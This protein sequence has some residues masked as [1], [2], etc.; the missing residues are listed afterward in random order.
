MRTSASCI[1]PL[2]VNNQTKGFLLLSIMSQ[3]KSAMERIQSGDGEE[4]KEIITGTT[5]KGG[6]ED[7]IDGMEHGS[8]RQHFLQS[9]VSAT[10]APLPH[11]I[12]SYIERNADFFLMPVLPLLWCL[13]LVA[14]LDHDSLVS[15]YPM[16]LLGV[17]SATLANAVPVGGGIVFVPILELFGVHIKLGTAFAVS[18]MT[19]GNGVF[20]FLNWMKKNPRVIAWEIMPAAILPAWIG[21]TIGTLRPL[22]PPEECRS[23]FAM[24][25]LA[26][27]VLVLRGLMVGKQNIKAGQPFSI[28]YTNDDNSLAVARASELHPWRTRFIA[29]ICSFLAGLILVAHIGIGNAVTSFLVSSFVWQLPAKQSVVTSIIIGG[30][31]SLCPFLLHLYILQDVPIALWVMGLPG[32]YFGAMIAPLVHEWM[33]IANV[34]SIFVMFLLLM[35]AMMLS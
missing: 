14:T 33:G 27:S 32:V 13:L 2:R 7:N 9:T 16:P 18:T 25:A 21:A 30:W 1:I 28:T 26:V 10:P 24:F 31:T 23:L 12:L 11:P 19:F 35:A 17:C 6:K 20:G 15:Y 29:S 5:T 4:E 3:Y 34:L 22:M 8:E